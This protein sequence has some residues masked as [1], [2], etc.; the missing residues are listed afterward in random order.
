MVPGITAEKIKK[1]FSYMD[2]DNSGKI[3]LNEFCFLL[4]GCKLSMNERLEGFSKEFNDQLKE[5]IKKAFNELDVNKNGRLTGNELE[6][7]FRPQQPDCNFNLERAQI[8]I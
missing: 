8:A 1:L 5:Q 4:D 2:T 3:S 7:M 6:A